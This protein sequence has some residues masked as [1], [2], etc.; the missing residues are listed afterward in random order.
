M[1]QDPPQ[2][3]ILSY[4]RFKKES[5]NEFAISVPSLYFY[6]PGILHWTDSMVQSF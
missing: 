1:P 4:T 2:L 6:C 3:E 5:R